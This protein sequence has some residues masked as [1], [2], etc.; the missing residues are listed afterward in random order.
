MCLVHL[1]DR[2]FC[3]PIIDNDAI[4]AKKKREMDEE[5]EKLK[6]EYEEKQRK[7]KEK[8]AE[9]EKGKEK[10][11]EKD[12][13]DNNKKDTDAGGKKGDSA[14]DDKV[15]RNEARPRSRGLC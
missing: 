11:T 15:W 5:V 1:K 12:T 9:K 7:K 6:K 8:E 10:E 2:G 14:S 3:S 4:A 13:Q